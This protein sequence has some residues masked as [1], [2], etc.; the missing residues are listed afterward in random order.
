M[1][2][3]Y[4]LVLSVSFPDHS[5]GVDRVGSEFTITRSRYSFCSTVARIYTRTLCLGEQSPIVHETFQ[6]FLHTA[7]SLSAPLEK[8]EK[9]LSVNRSTATP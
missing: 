7:G 8:E 3:Y 4:Q 5:H 9:I 2:L 1:H 6:I